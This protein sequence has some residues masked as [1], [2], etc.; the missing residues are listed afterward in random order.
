VKARVFLQGK[1]GLCA[2]VFIHRLVA[3]IHAKDSLRH[4]LEKQLLL[5]AQ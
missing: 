4:M 3:A 2:V 5:A 1:K